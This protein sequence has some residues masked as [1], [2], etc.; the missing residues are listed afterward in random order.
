MSWVLVPF[1][2]P[3]MLDSVRQ[4]FDRQQWKDKKL[5]IV[6]NGEAVGHC[7]QAGFT[8]DLL[9]QSDAHPS[10]ARNVGLAA[11][12][13]SDE[14]FCCMD[15][16]DWYGPY[17]VEEHVHAAARGRITGKITN[18]VHFESVGKL[19]LFNRQRAGTLVPW[20]Q[21]PTVG[22]YAR[23]VADFPVVAIGEELVLCKGHRAAGGE[24]RSTSVGHFIYLRST[25]ERKHIYRTTP[26]R[27][28]DEHGPWFEEHP[29]D[30]RLVCAGI[31]PVGAK[32]SY[33]QV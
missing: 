31:P 3:E 9:L 4:N 16:D 11:L 33:Q 24:V 7:K 22:G 2:R 17:Y 30:L 8:P 32:K 15:D 20:V 5:C 28:A 18:W 10:K 21:G 6:E 27:F 23:D 26:R 14:H 13:E 25:D 19:W 29:F 12:R 1:S